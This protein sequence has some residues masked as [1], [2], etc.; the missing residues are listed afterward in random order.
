[1]KQFFALVIMLMVAISCS[2]SDNFTDTDDTTVLV[3]DIQ[4][5][6]PQLVDALPV[7]NL[8]VFEPPAQS[9]TVTPF[10]DSP[11]LEMEVAQLAT[12]PFVLDYSNQKVYNSPALNYSLTDNHQLYRY[13]SKR[14][15][16]QGNKVLAVPWQNISWLSSFG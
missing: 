8:V 4:L 6:A 11:I 10:F 12:Q 5:D 9:V 3:A 14:Y 16:T 1:M 7:Q 15:N 2:P 13:R